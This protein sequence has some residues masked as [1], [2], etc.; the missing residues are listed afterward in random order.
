MIKNFLDGSIRLE[1]PTDEMMDTIRQLDEDNIPI[2]KIDDDRG[3]SS[4]S[5][6][7]TIGKE[8]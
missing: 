5:W 1:V 6:I 3:G 7:F 8:R 4:C 2:I